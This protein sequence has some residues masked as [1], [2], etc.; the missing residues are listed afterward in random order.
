M[1]FAVYSLEAL[2]RYQPDII[3]KDLLLCNGLTNP[4]TNVWLDLNIY[5]D[6]H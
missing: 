2:L 3:D 1:I 6:S 4:E 5:S